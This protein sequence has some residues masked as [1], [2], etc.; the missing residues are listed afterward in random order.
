MPESPYHGSLQSL[1]DIEA[2]RMLVL[3]YSRAVDRQD[4]AFLRGLYTEDAV[5]D[6]H[7]GAYS[8]SASG[9]VDWLERVMGRVENSAHMVHNHMIVLEGPER[10]QG[11]VYLSGH[12]RLRLEDGGCEDLTH[13]MR[14]LDHY[15]MTDGAWRFARR[16][17][18]VDWLTAGP[19]QW[20]PDRPDTRDAQFGRPGPVDPSYAVLSHPYFARRS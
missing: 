11:E 12:S 19:S 1:L 16:T 18:V 8:G 2:I 15:A 14:Y 9:Y 6:D 4:F 13:G 17:I 3:S 20:A 10:A 5:E 7:G